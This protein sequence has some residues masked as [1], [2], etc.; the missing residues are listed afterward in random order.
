MASKTEEEVIVKVPAAPVSVA[1]A[2]AEAAEK[3]DTSDLDAHA[4]AIGT[5]WEAKLKQQTRLYQKQYAELTRQVARAKAKEDGGTEAAEPITMLGGVPYQWWNLLLAGPFQAGVPTGPFLPRKIIAANERAFMIV[6]L[7]RNPL[8]LGG[9]PSAANIMSPF[10]YRV[11]L[12]TINLTAVVNGPDFTDPAPPAT[13]MFGGG[14]INVHTIQMPA[15]VFGTPAQGVPRLFE[16]N[17]TVDIIGPGVGLPAFAGFST[18]VF[19]PDTEPPFLFPFIPQVGFVFVPGVPPRLQHDTPAR[20][21][22]YA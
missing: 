19:D 7:W 21:L 20:F 9:G 4:N 16:V 6:A 13:A 2:A 3:Y 17:A 1:D 10:T 15:G 8:P 18:W 5:A 11:R 14:F 12:E 22:V